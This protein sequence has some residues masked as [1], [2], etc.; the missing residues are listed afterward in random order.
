MIHFQK[1]RDE[2]KNEVGVGWNELSLITPNAGLHPKKVMLRIWGNR[3][4]TAAPFTNSD[5]YCSKVN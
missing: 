4:D 5:K 2:G 1:E 3:K